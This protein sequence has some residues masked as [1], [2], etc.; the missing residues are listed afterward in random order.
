MME[1]DIPVSQVNRIILPQ[2]LRAEILVHL[3]QCAPNEGVGMLGV[4]APVRTETGSEVTASLFIPGRNT[5][6]S[7]V[8]YTMD[9]QDVIAAFRRFRESSL[10]LGAIVHSHLQ[11]P[12]TPSV[13]DVNE[14]NYP[15]SLMMIASFASHPTD[16]QAWSLVEE[17]DI[18]RVKRV[19]IL[20]ESD[21]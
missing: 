11:G 9:P 12:A 21:S 20:H 18:T 13:S 14:W 4:H 16:L 2:G 17:Q 19:Q 6:Q 10:V 8:R 15:E 3:L 5:E 7:P 1:P